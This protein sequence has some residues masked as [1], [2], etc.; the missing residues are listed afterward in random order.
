VTVHL[1]HP[2]AALDP[3]DV[4]VTGVPGRRVPPYQVTVGDSSA[5]SPDEGNSLVIS[6]REL[7]GHS[8]YRVTIGPSS[9][10]DH[11]VHPF[12]ASAEFRFTIDCDTGD[13]S[14]AEVVA[15][16]AAVQ[17]PS[18]DLLTK[19]Y[20]GFIQ[21]LTEWVRVRH[22]HVTD[23]STASFERMVLEQLAWL[24]DMLSYHQDRVANEAFIETASQRFSLRQHAVLLGTAL[25]DGQ[26]PTT[27]LAFEPTVSGFV[28]AGL[29]VRMRGAADEVPVVFTVSRRTRVRTA[30]NTAALVVAAFT[31]AYN[32]VLPAGATSLLLWGHTAELDTGDR[33][34]LVQGPFS[35]VV[36]LDRPPVHRLEAGWVDEPGRPYAPGD[37][38][39]E[40]TELH[41]A[42]PL[43]RELRPWSASP[44]LR[45]HANLADADYGA[46]RRAV[47]GIGAT[48]ARGDVPLALTRRTSIVTQHGG[49]R[50]LRALQLPE[51]PVVHAEGGDG[52][53]RP[54]I[55]L[56]VA[57]ERW[58]QV[59]HLHRSFSYDL[60]YTAEASEDGTAWL[61]FGEG[62]H[63]H[64][65]PVTDGGELAVELAVRYRVGDPATGNLGLG[66]LTEIVRPAADTDEAD[67]LDALGSL[68]VTNV[69][70]GSGGRGPSSLRRVKEEIPWSL[71]NGPLERAVALEDYA[72]A[73]MQ[74]PGTARAT[75]RPVGGPFNT[76]MV[77]VD[78]EGSGDDPEELRQR[79]HTHLDRL[80][81]TGREHVVRAAVYV[82]LD[83]EL[84]LCAQDGMPPHTVRR[85]VLAELEP[86]SSE[87][88]GWFHP[89]RLTFGSVVRLGDLLAFVQG[90]PGV[91]SVTAS[92][93]RPLGDSSGP[94][95]RHAIE[96]HGTRV[97]RLDAD[98]DRPEHGRLRVLL[99]GVDEDAPALAVDGSR[100]RAR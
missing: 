51:G 11:P 25:D 36:T 33:L 2:G 13:C 3:D 35:Q 37:P 77:L 24:G 22:P 90:I 12:F 85:R 38:P 8:P 68:R 7:G 66:T 63:G 15:G 64:E 71:R 19:D 14:P 98:P 92:T 61:R 50:R 60:H 40:V 53:P 46:P 26:G 79:V 88:P 27:V 23:L 5:G 16:R 75:A 89:D 41:W 20:N 39:A 29:Q 95:V 42:E 78:P 91:R 54:A 49:A 86:G 34:A 80:R 59:E 94:V 32:A 55:E 81:M 100:R 67:A 44:P 21:L 87:R 70:R 47:G 74:V 45:L 62:V 43:T 83:V 69:V 73:A 65:V 18:V 30:N 97:A 9:D 72:T 99:P 28:P 48:L 52:R 93:F 31:G 4:V 96:L 57:G 76:V 82:P 17:P 56:T 6:F 1:N 58:T 84:V 10:P